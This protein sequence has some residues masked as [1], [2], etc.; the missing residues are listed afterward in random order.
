MRAL[1]MLVAAALLTGCTAPSSDPGPSNSGVIPRETTAVTPAAP[2]VALPA[3]PITDASIAAWA[4]SQPASP[5]RLVIPSL[6]LDMGIAPVGIAPDSTMEI[7]ESASVAG[8]YEHGRA[9]ASGIGNT[10]V[11]AHVDDSTIGLGPFAG[12][13]ELAEGTQVDVTDAAGTV[14]SFTVTRVEQTAKTTVDSALLFA[15]EGQ[16]QLVLVTCGGRW[17]EGRQHYDDNVI[18]WAEP[19]RVPS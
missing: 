12:L 17:D 15:R 14:H 7:P 3:P 10:V 19:M 9:P 11:A 13:K 6:G 16:Q 4:S 8:W 18:V 1:T 2:R 5:S